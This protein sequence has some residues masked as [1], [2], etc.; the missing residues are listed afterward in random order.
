MVR[1]KTLRFVSFWLAA[2]LRENVWK[3]SLGSSLSWIVEEQYWAP[4]RDLAVGIWD[5]GTADLVQ[6]TFHVAAE[7]LRCVCL[8]MIPEE[9]L[10]KHRKRQHCILHLRSQ[11]STG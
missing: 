9:G 7:S 2:S 4:R 5:G 10:R 11:L 3:V 8:H 6:T 1:E